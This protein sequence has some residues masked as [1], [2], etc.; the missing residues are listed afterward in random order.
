[1]AAKPQFEP[2][3]FQ[4]Y[5][6]PNYT[7][8]P[9]QL[10]DE[11]LS[12]LSGAE[13]KVVLYICRR[14]FG[15]KRDSDNISL[16][17]M[18]HGIVTHDGRRLDSGTG[19]SKP[20]LISA[21]KSLAEK[22]IVIAQQ[23]TSAEKGNE[24]TNYRLNI[25]TP[26]GKKSE[27]GESNNF[28]PLGKENLLGGVN[29]ID[30]GLVKKV[31]QALGKKSLPTINSSTTN[32]MTINSS[33]N[34]NSVSSDPSLH[35]DAVVVVLTSLGIGK[36][37]AQKLADEHNKNYLREKIE[38][39]EFLQAERPEEVQ[40]PAGWLRKAIEDDY[41]PP[42]GYQSVAEREVEAIKEQQHQETRQRLEAES[43]QRFHAE[44]ARKAEEQAQKQQEE[45][46]RLA[47]LYEQ[48]G[49]TAEE[50]DVWQQVLTDLEMKLS[51]AVFQ[52]HLT[53]SAL[54]TVREGEAIVGLK[55]HFTRDWVANRL[56]DKI[57]RALVKHVGEVSLRLN[58][59]SFQQAEEAQAPA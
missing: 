28:T 55:N 46:E 44:Q 20:A 1:M 23:R 12:L 2:F 13:L 53:G 19:L 30:Q 52:G 45:A 36:K 26:L 6:S 38:F 49:T 7:P 56:A 40:K 3:H 4:G 58:F 11:H 43:A 25:R 14:T 34:N 10:L 48:Y 9:D 27:L 33:N 47:K 39:L 22:N 50:Q 57:Q 24:A 51:P 54:F 17:Q 31:D 5:D 41:G 37:V 32:S 42:A 18:L 15:F 29:K 16:N 59:V 35:K 21:L 8:V